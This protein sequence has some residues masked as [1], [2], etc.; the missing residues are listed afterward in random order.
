MVVTGIF[1]GLAIVA[2]GL[3]LY[4]SFTESAD[5]GE[6]AVIMIPFALP[7]IMML[8]DSLVGSDA[9]TW[10]VYPVFILLVFLNGFLLYCLFGGL[11]RAP[12]S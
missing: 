6:S 4:S 10:A 1:V 12:S 11:R 3:H 2:L 9:W 7:W 5:S 8:P